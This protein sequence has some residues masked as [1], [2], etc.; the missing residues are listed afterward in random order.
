MDDQ[1]YQ[2]IWDADMRGNGV[3]ALRPDE[4]KTPS[5]GYVV[6]DERSGTLGTDHKVLAEVLLPEAK[7]ATY[8]L[9]ERL[10][11]NYALERAASEVIRPSETQEE[12]D[13]INACLPT[14][15]MQVARAYL[16]R[17]LNLSIS[18]ATLAGMLH[19][20]WFKFARA[21]GQ[22]D[23]TGFEHV[24]VGEQAKKSSGIGGYHFWYKYHLDDGARRIEL[25]DSP[26]DRIE[27]HGTRYDKSEMPEAGLL[28]PDV[29][30][31]SMVWDAPAGDGGAARRLSKPIGGFFVGLSPEGLMAMGLVRSRA[32]SGKIA[33]INEATYQLDLHRLDGSPNAI[34]TFFPRF[35]RADFLPTGP[36][37]SPSPSPAPTPDPAPEPTPPAPGQAAFRVI[38]AMVN[39]V[40]PEGGREF[41]QIMNTGDHKASLL[42]WQIV[43]PNGR[44]F[45]LADIP[46]APG[47]VHKSVLPTKDGILR[48]RGGTIQLL[49]PDGAQVQACTYTKDMAQIEGAPILF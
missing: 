41:L 22:R 32:P 1:I 18:D 30:T 48:N 38:G 20:T 29:V 24:F 2:D 15:P 43:A 14:P 13:L 40:N 6:V 46:L 49:D 25:P 39:P 7:R 27:Y 3:P 34:R 23:A 42:D 4:E 11:D 19:E 16:E 35:V 5:T 33:R 45:R 37:P 28:V 47:D 12:W 36:V 9:C 10:F 8:A 44:A 21:G 26:V 31:L 17:A